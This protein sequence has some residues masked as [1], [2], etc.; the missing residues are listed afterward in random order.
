MERNSFD[1]T[2]HRTACRLFHHWSY[3]YICIVLV[4]FLF[5]SCFFCYW[6]WKTVKEGLGGLKGRGRGKM[7]LVRA[8]TIPSSVFNEQVDKIWVR[9]VE[10]NQRNEREEEEDEEEEEEEG[11]I[12]TRPAA[13]ID[14]TWHLTGDHINMLMQS[15]DNDK[16]KRKK[17]VRKTL[18]R[19]WG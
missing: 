14:K 6:Y 5:D 15:V 12:G 13:S 10:K 18:V 19:E 8:D 11:R 9:V 2:I 17:R 16:S 4:F 7:T 1:Q 3:I